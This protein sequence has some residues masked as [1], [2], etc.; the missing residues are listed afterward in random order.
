MMFSSRVSPKF[1][2]T[3]ER[4]LAYQINKKATRRLPPNARPGEAH[5]TEAHAMR[6]ETAADMKL[7]LVA[8][9]IAVPFKCEA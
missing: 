4:S 7:L 8:I 3:N 5:R 6:G 9:A 2:L 1:S